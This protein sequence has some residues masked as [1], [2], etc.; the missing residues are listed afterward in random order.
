[1][2]YDI[3]CHHL[4]GELWNSRWEAIYKI[5]TRVFR[6]PK[7]IQSNLKKEQSKLIKHISNKINFEIQ[8][9][10]WLILL[11]V[12]RLRFEYFLNFVNILHSQ[13][14]LFSLV[15]S[16]DSIQQKVFYTSQFRKQH[17]RAPFCFLMKWDE[18]SECLLFLIKRIFYFVACGYNKM[19]VQN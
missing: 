15:F 7:N 11:F 19:N 1:M 16:L 14:F 9:F 10:Q 18:W 2:Y 3:C 17:I 4:Y 12:P 13:N 8:T 6:I 5:K